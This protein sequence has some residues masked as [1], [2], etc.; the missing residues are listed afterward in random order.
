MADTGYL[1]VLGKHVE[2]DGNGC[3][4]LVTNFD[5]IRYNR[6][7]LVRLV[8]EDEASIQTDLRA[9]MHIDRLY[10]VTV[11]GGRSARKQRSL[12]LHKFAKALPTMADKEF[13]DF[14]ADV[15]THGVNNPILVLKGTDQ[16]LDGRHRVAVADAL[17]LEMRVTEFEGTEEHARDRVLSENVHR[18]HLTMA[19]TSPWPN[20][21]CW[22]ANSTCPKHEK[23]PRSAIPED[24]E[25]AAVRLPPIGRSLPTS[26]KRPPRMRMRWPKT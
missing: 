25:G 24:H 21:D 23:K 16:V 15:R 17:G 2:S 1:G 3:Y 4:R 22:S 10:H 20:G 8:H 18:R 13:E 5:A 6:R 19:D 26:M 7:K 11:V 14:V 12:R 9:S